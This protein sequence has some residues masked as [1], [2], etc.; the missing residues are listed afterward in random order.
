MLTSR[1]TEF[2]DCPAFYEW[3]NWFQAKLAI[4]IQPQVFWRNINDV[5]LV[6][7]LLFNTTKQ[8]YSGIYGIEAERSID[9]T[10]T[11]ACTGGVYVFK[12]FL[13]M[14]QYTPRG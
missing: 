11:R 3:L 10:I 1:L 6:G 13:D 9:F 2:L 8:F 4:I 14:Y 7:N 5:S 12:L